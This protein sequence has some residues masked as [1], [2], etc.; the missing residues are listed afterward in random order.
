MED[1]FSNEIAWDENNEVMK[2]DEFILRNGDP[3]FS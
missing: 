2:K 3:E 1:D